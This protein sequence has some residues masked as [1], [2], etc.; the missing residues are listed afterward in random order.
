M[1]DPIKNSESKV[2]QIYPIDKDEEICY[3]VHSV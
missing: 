1:L 3:S 2:N